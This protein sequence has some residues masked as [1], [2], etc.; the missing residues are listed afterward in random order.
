MRSIIT[1][2]LMLVAMVGCHSQKE[3]ATQSSQ[4]A[5]PIDHPENAKPCN[6]V[7]YHIVAL[8][9]LELGV[10][11]NEDGTFNEEDTARLAYR[12][13]QEFRRRGTA[14][15]FF[16]HCMKFNTGQ[17]E[18]MKTANRMP[19]LNLCYQLYAEQPR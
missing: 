4:V 1:S 10:P 11:M 6:D 9:V 16:N 2:F 13:D 5:E 15:Q 12:V 7:Y 14:S 19:V 8:S 18:C 17:L 3:V